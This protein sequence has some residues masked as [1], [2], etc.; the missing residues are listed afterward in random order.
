[1]AESS[2][3]EEEGKLTG[4]NPQLVVDDDLRDMAK[5]AAWSVSSC[6]PG[7]GVASLRDDNLDTYWQSDGAQPHLVNIQF[8][9]KVK[10]QLV[11]LYVDFKLDESYT[12]SKISIRAGD[13]FHNLKEIKTVELVKP[14]GWVYIS[15]SGSDPRETFVNTFMLQIAVL[16]N[17]LNGRDTHLRQIKV[18]GPRPPQT[19]IMLQLT[20]TELQEFGVTNAETTEARDALVQFMVKLSPGEN[21]REVN[22]GWNSSSDPCKDGWKGVTCKRNSVKRIDLDKLNLTGELDASSLCVAEALAVLNLSSNNVVG[23]LPEEISQCRSLTQINLHGNS[24]SG[25]LPAS[26]SRLGNLRRLDVSDNGFSGNIPGLARISGLLTFLVQDNQLSGGIPAFDFTNLGAFNVSNNNLSGP[27]PDVGGKFDETCFLG[28]PGLCGKPLSEACPPPPPAKTKFSIKKEYFICGGYSVI[29]VIIACLVAYKLI[30]K[31]NMIVMK[32]DAK[33]GIAIDR[34]FNRTCSS[35]IQ[36]RAVD[37]KISE[38][39]ITSVESGKG[40][41]SLVVLSSPVANQL[42]FDD[43]LRSPAVLVGRGRRGTLYK[44]FINEV[45]TLAVKRI[46]DWDIS[47]DDFKTRM[48]R[49]DLVKHPNVIPFLAFYCSRQEKLVVYEFQKNSS[50][51]SLLHGSERGESLDWPSR[52]GIA[53]KISGVLAF[54]H[55]GLQ[56]DGIAHGNI[57]TSNILFNN[58]MQPCISEYGLAEVELQG[59]SFL[60]QTESFQANNPPV[61][62]KAFKTDTYNFGLVLLELLTGEP[63]QNN[64]YDLARLINSTTRVE[65]TAEVLDRSLVSES[66]D[67][68]QMLSLLQLA[69]KCINTSTP[70]MIEIAET[71]KSIASTREIC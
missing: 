47:V 17:H 56:T 46:K 14:T 26:L 5:K 54:M 66:S 34:R 43:L 29:G 1:M 41:T 31:R 25:N 44:V 65:L 12:P 10:L 49:I 16:S 32:N 64:G 53:A 9:K 37:G 21:Q 51:F 35:S 11:V 48:Q 30:K 68:E 42:S 18:Y 27:I 59:Q 55:E 71:I 62:N 33:K 67:K 13:G 69:M 28:N 63:V 3:G 4:G 39:S 6:K 70:R 2:E 22:W 19:H 24:F 7:N 23:T 20:F 58:E 57:K 38:F 40:S 8:Q 52:L 50:L 15:L 60:D 36:S 45:M 61:Q